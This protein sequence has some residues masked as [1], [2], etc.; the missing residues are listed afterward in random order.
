MENH[1]TEVK[2]ALATFV[3]V[4]TGFWGWLG[5][6]VVCW[7]C[8]MVLDYITGSMAAG[9][10]GEWTSQR[11]R[12]GIFHKGGMLVIVLVAAATDLLVSLVLDNLPMLALPVEYGGLVCPVVLV[13]YIVTELGSITENAVAM[14]APVPA[15]LTKLLKVSKDAV[16]QIGGE[17]V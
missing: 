7:I 4:L 15:L 11:A 5:W 2:L 10:A 1:L 8:C 16:D 13:W 17:D 9:K 6:L 3:G 12:E 14:G